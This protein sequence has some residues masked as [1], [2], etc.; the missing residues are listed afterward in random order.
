VAVLGEVQVPVGVAGDAPTVS[1]DELMM[2]VA[3]ADQVVP[4]RRPAV[5]VEPDVV[6]LV[7]AGST[8]REAAVF[9][10]GA[11]GGAQCRGDG[12][13]ARQHSDDLPGAVHDEGGKGGI[14]GQDAGLVCGDRGGGDT[15][16]VQPPHPRS[17]RGRSLRPDEVVGV[18]VDRDARSGPVDGR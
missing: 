13:G 16:A 14:A 4:G 18:D 10:A 15:E 9:I 5:G 17:R 11:D 2:V 6:H 1:V 12:A 8:V 3:Q 7:D